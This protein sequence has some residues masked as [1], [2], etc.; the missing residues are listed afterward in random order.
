MAQF[1]LLLTPR[2]IGPMGSRLTVKDFGMQDWPGRVDSIHFAFFRSNLSIDAQQIPYVTISMDKRRAAWQALF[3]A[4]KLVRPHQRTSYTNR[5][6]EEFPTN[7]VGAQIKTAYGKT[8]RALAEADS[9]EPDTVVRRCAALWA[10][11]DEWQAGLRPEDVTTPAA[12]NQLPPLTRAYNFY[13]R[14]GPHFHSVAPLADDAPEEMDFHGV[15]AR[16]A[17]HPILLR[18]L[19]LLIDFEVPVENLSSR[20][21]PAELFAVPNWPVPDDNPPEGWRNAL[22]DDLTPRTAY[23]LDGTRFLPNSE[24]PHGLL[25]LTGTGPAGSGT[26]PRFEIMPVDVD[27]AALRMVGA[28]LSDRVQQRSPEDD[29]PNLPALRSMGFALVDTCR[30]SEH[31][32]RLNRADD[33]ARPGNLDVQG[34]PLSAENLVAGYRVDVSIFDDTT[35]RPGPWQSLCQRRVRY[36]LENIEIPEGWSAGGANLGLPEEGFLRP[37]SMTT[38][39]GANDAVYIHQTVARFDGWSMVA[40]RPDRVDDPSAIILPSSPLEVYVDVQLGSLP[41]LRFGRKYLLRVRLADLVGGGLR[42]AEVGSDEPQTELFKHLRFEP[43]PPPELVPTRAY[44]DGE[45]QGVLVVRSDRGMSA[46]DYASTHGYSPD[47]FRYLYPPKSSL[48]LALQYDGRFDD[49]LGPDTDT[50]VI[51]K[52]FEI[53]KRADRDFGDISGPSLAGESDGTCPYFIVPATPAAVPWLPDPGAGLMSILVR[54]RPIDPDTGTQGRTQGFEKK[55]EWTHEPVAGWADLKPI[56]LR[57]T[58]GPSGNTGCEAKSVFSENQWSLTIALSPAQQATLD[59]V[60]CPTTSHVTSLGIAIWAGASDSSSNPVNEHIEKGKNP[61]VTPPRTITVVHAVQR[62]LKDPSGRLNEN[63]DR[64]PGETHVDLLV[65]E[66]SIDVP[67]TGRMDIR[68]KW[69]DFEDIPARMPKRE[70]KEAEIGS[71]DVQHLRMSEALAG[72]IRQEFGDTRRRRVT[73]TVK[74]ISRFRDYF[75]RI[76]ATNPDACTVEGTLELTDITSSARPPSLTLRYLMPS[77]S[78]S[79]VGEGTSEVKST[80]FGGRL[81]VFLERPWFASGSDEAL[82]VIVLPAGARVPSAE[83]LKLLSLAGRDPTWNT[84]STPVLLNKGHFNATNSTDEFLREFGGNVTAMVHPIDFDRNF[85]KQANCWWVDIDL[86]PLL[87][88][89]YFPFVRLSLARYQQKTVTSSDRLSPPIVSEPIQL[90][91][92]RELTVRRTGS[93]R[94]VKIS[95]IGP[96]GSRSTKIQVDL[97][98]FPGNPAAADKALIGPSG[99]T[100]I[101]TKPNVLLNSDVVLDIPSDSR[102]MRICVTETEPY[103]TE[104]S[105]AT[106]TPSRLVYADIIPL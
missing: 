62:P 35:Q 71:Y 23:V 60:S 59:V 78:W 47:E 49:A 54:S 67:S 15:I 100:T 93:Q 5:Q 69:E 102:P 86:S 32:K 65:R 89:S 7:E 3:P 28:A 57:V 6:V 94:I 2:L 79:R 95:G 13:R 61:N 12:S 22:Q 66:I 88:L 40:K 74:A 104:G 34:P 82:A 21:A 51:K 63:P 10:I 39:G 80:R 103:P 17:D 20:T 41:R 106:S 75:G 70:V 96:A 24:S 44:T 92:H 84:G 52:F 73:Y 98:V 91:P 87:G 68:A 9:D 38:G 33:R 99:W 64:K 101:G 1:S 42:A 43:I 18:A 37:D 81:R 27:G 19:G 45:G 25:P 50:S 97:Q 14:E 11:T 56:P 36:K 77:F 16:L 85:D 105:S 72:N 58:D 4:I 8:A 29:P 26:N 31:A 48:E 90:F 83:Q 46:Q 53:A 76:T 55:C 30:V